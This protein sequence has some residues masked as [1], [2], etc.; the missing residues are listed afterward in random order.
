MFG[1]ILKA[2]LSEDPV[3]IS[4]TSAQDNFKDGMGVDPDHVATTWPRGGFTTVSEITVRSTKTNR[5][6]AAIVGRR[7]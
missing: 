1:L 5:D 3:T 6:R 7:P 4:L 2:N